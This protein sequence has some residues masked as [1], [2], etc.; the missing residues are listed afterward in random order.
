MADIKRLQGLAAVLKRYGQ[1]D[2]LM[3]TIAD[4]PRVAT[5]NVMQPA[6][7]AWSNMDYLDRAALAA[8]PVPVLGDLL[9]FAA[10]AKSVYQQ[11]TLKNI[12]LMGLGA[13][14]FAPSIG[15]V[16]ALRAADSP[17]IKFSSKSPD[18]LKFGKMPI[19]K[20]NTTEQLII[21]P[22]KSAGTL[23]EDMEMRLYRLDSGNY[24]IERR[25]QWASDRKGFYAEG[26]DLDALIK[27]AK[28]RGA[29][30]D[31][32]VKAALKSKDKLSEIK[33]KFGEENLIFKDSER[34]KSS[35]I[36]H[37][38]SGLKIRISD[39][40]LPIGYEQA[41]LDLSSGLSKEQL[42]KAISD[43]LGGD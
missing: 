7:N 10:D 9:G 5:E 37:K 35:Y 6:K 17:A 3:R 43:F 42:T 27:A 18:G 40:K 28:T 16:K 2:P 25:P 30:S 12:G 29:R 19:E 8:A 21:Y 33:E 20:T 13:L 41:D 14:P 36:I 31:V 32:A 38:P 34:S 11:P 23:A 15:M 26:P 39:H 4:I 22:N 24:A 1:D